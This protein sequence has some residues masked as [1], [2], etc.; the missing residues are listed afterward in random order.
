MLRGHQIDV[1]DPEVRLKY[2]NFTTCLQIHEAHRLSPG[3]RSAAENSGSDPYSYLDF[4]DALELER[5]T[6]GVPRV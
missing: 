4:I 6:G 2:S 1:I 5:D 3:C